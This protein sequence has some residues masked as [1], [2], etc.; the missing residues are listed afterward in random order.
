VHVTVITVDQDGTSHFADREIDLV[1]R[2]YAPPA[3]PLEVSD[4]VPAARGMFFR[5]PSGWF[6]DW[7]PSPRHQYFVQTTGLLDVQVGDGEV[8][9]LGPGTVVLLEDTPGPGHTTRVV[10]PDAVCGVFLHLPD[11]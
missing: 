11:E 8:R 5:M 9:R 2:A 1:A 4:P 10:G 7:H 6:G 3:P